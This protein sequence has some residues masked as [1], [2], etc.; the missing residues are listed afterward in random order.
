MWVQREK[1]G[2]GPKGKG[3][4][5]APHPRKKLGSHGTSALRGRRKNRLWVKGTLEP[6]HK[7][8][9][10]SRRKIVAARL[11]E[12]AASGP[13]GNTDFRPAE[14]PML[15]AKRG[16]EDA[17][18]A[19]SGEAQYKPRKVTRGAQVAPCK[20]K[21]SPRALI[22]QG[23]FV[24]YG[25]ESGLQSTIHMSLAIV[26]NLNEVLY[27]VLFVVACLFF[28]RFVCIRWICFG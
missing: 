12:K 18:G 23:C 13:S 24:G 26:G 19:P 27:Y 5:R 14:K 7:M 6:Y 2:L 9:L 3:G 15:K 10:W 11:K 21:G 17:S 1:G 22:A 16:S 8:W 28:P 20:P 25:R 4:W